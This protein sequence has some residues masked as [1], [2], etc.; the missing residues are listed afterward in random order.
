M[1]GADVHV[2]AVASRFAAHDVRPLDADVAAI[3]GT[4]ERR[5]A[6]LASARDDRGV[7]LGGIGEPRS[8]TRCRDQEGP[9]E[10]PGTTNAERDNERREQ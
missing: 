2:H 5:A 8:S 6:Y 9:S 3:S 4:Q 1:N 10:G 7:R